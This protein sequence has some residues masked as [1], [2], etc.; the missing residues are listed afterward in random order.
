MARANPL[1]LEVWHFT[2]RFVLPGVGL[3]TPVDLERRVIAYWTQSLSWGSGLMCLPELVESL[4]QI[5]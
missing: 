2:L 1:F 4:R 3:A 5:R